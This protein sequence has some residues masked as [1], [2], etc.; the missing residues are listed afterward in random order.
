MAEG[1]IPVLG[2]TACYICGGH[3]WASY[4]CA[5]CE[6]PICMTHTKEGNDGKPYCP[7]HIGAHT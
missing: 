7:E 1:E 4:F 5:Q 2:P 6:R 3:H